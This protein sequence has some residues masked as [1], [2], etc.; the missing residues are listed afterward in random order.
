MR[1]L[2]LLTLP[3][4]AAPALA[5]SQPAPRP[6]PAPHFDVAQLWVPPPLPAPPPDTDTYAP[7][8]EE[9]EEAP[10][11]RSAREQVAEAGEAFVFALAAEVFL[12]PDSE[13]VPAAGAGAVQARP[14][15]FSGRPGPV[16]ARRAV[17]LVGVRNLRRVV[18]HV[19]DDCSGL[20]RASYESAGIDL[21]GGGFRPGENAV[22]AIWR[23]ARRQG[24]LHR[25]TPH[26]GDLVFFRE[27]YDRN[28]DGRRNDG[29]THIGVVESVDPDGTVTFI[30]RASK[31][32]TRSKLNPRQPRTFRTPRGETLN[33]YLRPASKRLRAYLTGELFVGYAAADRLR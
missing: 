17:K 27:T 9:A 25:H 14:A 3:L 10:P 1:T 8:P 13:V 15:T 24:A 4:L 6:V 23:L 32:V 2:A 5:A 33:D 31:G 21:V 11:T 29:L 28:R 18:R 22:T 26:P 19:P 7:Q 12:P 16:I 20:V 30:H